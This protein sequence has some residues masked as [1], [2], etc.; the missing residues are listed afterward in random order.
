[1]RKVV[2]KT[3]QL[4]HEEVE[5]LNRFGIGVDDA[6]NNIPQHLIDAE[7]FM[8]GQIEG[9]NGIDAA[10]RLL[11]QEIIVE[12][13]L[14]GLGHDRKSFWLLAFGRLIGSRH[15]ILPER[16]QPLPVGIPSSRL[17]DAATQRAVDRIGAIL[18]V[19]LNSDVIVHGIVP[20]SL[21]DPL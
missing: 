15:S 17:L 11:R 20:C 19:S 4:I 10:P 18:P 7:A 8:T 2:E 6:V 13:F 3:A 5:F 21:R 12:E 14:V 9:A 1:M 16:L